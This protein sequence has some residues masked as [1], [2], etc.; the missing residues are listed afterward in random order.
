VFDDLSSDSDLLNLNL[1][2]ALSMIFTFGLMQYEQV[3]A[4]EVTR[5]IN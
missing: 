1:T 5:S 4:A 2:K 3:K